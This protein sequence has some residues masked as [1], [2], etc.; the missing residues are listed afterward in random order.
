MKN[1][2]PSPEKPSNPVNGLEPISTEADRYNPIET[3]IESGNWPGDFATKGFEMADSRNSAKS[4][5]KRP[6]TSS[7]SQSVKDGVV[8]VQYSAAYQ[9]WIFTKGLDMDVLKGEECVSKESKAQC[10]NLQKITLNA[11]QPSI[12]PEG[13][14]RKVLNKCQNRNEALVNRD[15]TPM[16]VPPIMSLYFG[17]ANHLEHVID[18]VNTDWDERCVLAGPQLR[19][20][21]A[22]GLFSSAFTCEEI[23]KLNNYTASDNWTRFTGEM[24][25]PFLMCEVKCGKEGLDVADRQNMHSSSVALRAILRIEQEADKYRPGKRLASLNGQILVF[26]ISHDQKDARLYGHYALLH[27]DKWTYHR[28]F[29]NSFNLLLN[30]NNVLDVLALYNFVQN[31]FKSHLPI[32][33]QRLKDALAAFPEPGVLSSAASGVTSTDENFQQNQPNRDADGFV[34]PGAPASVSRSEEAAMKQQMDI[35]VQQMEKQQR[36]QLEQQRQSAEREERM[37]QESKLREEKMQKQLDEL[38]KLVASTKTTT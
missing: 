31:L 23:D 24:Y 1:D 13:S 9:R 3:W 5:N 34:M 2:S 16:L 8:P 32:H 19:P 14:L 10:I 6:R 22:I 12:F 29:I 33:V 37:R 4:S 15:V 38:M 11:I 25:F 30:R 21:L 36:E 35:L 17:G 27:G 7:Y 20:D 18:E 26:S 28:Y